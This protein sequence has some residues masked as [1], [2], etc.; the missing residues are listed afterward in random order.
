[1]HA[2]PGRGQ[3]VAAP[4][5]IQELRGQ[6]VKQHPYSGLPQI[7]FRETRRF[8]SI[9]VAPGPEPCFA[10]SAPSFPPATPG[11]VWLDWRSHSEEPRVAGSRA[12]GAKPGRGRG[13]GGRGAGTRH[14]RDQE[15]EFEPLE[16]HLQQENLHSVGT[17]VWASWEGRGSLGA[18]SPS[19]LRHPRQVA[20][21]LLSC[22]H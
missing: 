14:R 12:R 20:T 5:E 1:M 16:L 22:A 21:S 2:L 8:G 6:F 17:Q 7:D 3:G 4:A 19:A 11:S 9:A 18:F 15:R 13:S 10:L